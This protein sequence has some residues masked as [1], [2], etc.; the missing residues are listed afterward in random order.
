MKEIDKK[1]NV[2]HIIFYFCCCWSF[3]NRYFQYFFS[4]FF[5]K[6]CKG[7]FDISK[8]LAFLIT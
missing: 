8:G 1:I 5:L 2:I 4:K 6:L 3:S 7:V